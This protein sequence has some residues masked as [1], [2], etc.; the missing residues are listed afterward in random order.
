MRLQIELYVF[1][2]M[3]VDFVVVRQTVDFCGVEI[4]E[5]MMAVFD[6]VLV[7]GSR[8]AFALVVLAADQAGVDVVV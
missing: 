1:E 4:D 2:R 5:E 8:L 6:A 3:G 7:G